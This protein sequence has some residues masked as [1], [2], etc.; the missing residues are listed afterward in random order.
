MNNITTQIMKHELPL[1]LI[2]LTT[3]IFFSVDLSQR[4]LL[5][6]S[7]PVIFVGLFAWL[8]FIILWGAFRVAEHVD[9]LA[10]TMREPFGTL[11]LTI[12]VISIEIAAIVSIMLTGPSSPNLARDT[13]YSIIMILLNGVV[14]LSLLLGG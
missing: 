3:L 9:C 7:Y 13:M 6:F 4:W 1:W 14:G 11:V 5:N 8:T 12:S 2:W 10:E